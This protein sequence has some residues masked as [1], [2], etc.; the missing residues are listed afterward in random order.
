MSSLDKHLLHGIEFGNKKAYYELYK[1]YYAALVVYAV[2]FLGN[3]EE[4]EDVVQDV[5]VALWEKGG[6]FESVLKLV[7]FLYLSVHNRCLNVL[8]SHS[9]RDRYKQY[10]Q[11]NNLGEEDLE[12]DIMNREAIRML[13]QLVDELPPRCREVFLLHMDGRKNEEIAVA[14]DIALDTVKN[15]KKK[16]IAFLKKRMGTLF[17]VLLHMEIFS[18]AA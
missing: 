10:F 9:I 4:A 14:L 7:N 11:T 12:E 1:R 2:K 16:A 18:R 5:L 13:W 3:K 8:K 15:Q 6:R 17:V